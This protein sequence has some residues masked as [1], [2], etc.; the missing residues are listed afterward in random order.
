MSDAGTTP[1]HHV[2]AGVLRRDGRVLL[3]HRSPDRRWYPGAWDLPGGHVGAGEQPSS[4]LRRELREELGVEGDVVGEP[5]ASVRGRDFRMDIWVVDR[6][7]GEP[8]NCAPDE[9]DALAW[10]SPDELGGLVLADHRLP[11]LLRAVA[12]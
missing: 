7:T 12:R 5:F 6:W 2:V 11:E 3:A 4:A 10:L 1:P 8:T 9:H